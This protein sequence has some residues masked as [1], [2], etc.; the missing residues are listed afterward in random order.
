M[1]KAKPRITRRNASLEWIILLECNL[2]LAYS[3]IGVLTK[4]L[5]DIKI[6]ELYSEYYSTSTGVGVLAILLYWRE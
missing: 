6:V 5:S 3:C 2:L 4:I 1:I